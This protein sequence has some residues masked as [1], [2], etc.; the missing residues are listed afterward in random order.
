MSI[1]RPVI[2]IIDPCC[3]AGYDLNVASNHILGGTEATV[4][5]IVGAL[6]ADFEFRLYQ[7]NRASRHNGGSVRVAP[8]D[9]AFT[10]TGCDGFVVINSWKV[11]CR[12]R[13]FH[14][15]KPISLWLHVHPGRH[16]RA[17]GEALAQARIDVICV[18]QSH[19]RQLRQFLG[20]GAMPTIRHIW[21]PIADD[22]VGDDT[23]RR[24]DRLLFASAPHKGLTEVLARFRELRRQLPHLVLE[25]ADPGY[26]AWDVGPIPEGVWMRGRLP[27]HVLVERMRRALCLFYPQTSFAETFGLVIAEANAVGMPVLVQQ[28]L[29]AND[30][31]VCGKDQ[32]VDAT[33]VE[34]LAER[35]VQWQTHF[36]FVQTHAKFRLSNVR[37]LWHAR[38]SSMLATRPSG[39]ARAKQL[40]E[41]E[42]AVDQG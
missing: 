21:N 22:L 33:D 5:R 24:S 35:I 26:L 16:N 14:P 9:D 30:E 19:A 34:I 27:H 42:M 39:H 2:G 1:S 41:M 15:R 37:A 8:L 17:M 32:L 28:G 20:S 4:L 12:L 36:P 13:R 11:A 40:A 6:K 25:V 3:S 18:S 10:S 23:A 31:V 7:A 38:L 29:G